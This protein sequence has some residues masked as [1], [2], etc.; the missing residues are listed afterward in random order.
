MPVEDVTAVPMKM[1]CCS[2]PTKV[3]PNDSFNEFDNCGLLGEPCLAFRLY[4]MLA[5]AYIHA[6]IQYLA[7]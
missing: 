6:R 4:G 3:S 1:V 7:R 5:K 2:E